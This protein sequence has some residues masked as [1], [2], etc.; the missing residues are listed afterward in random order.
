MHEGRVNGKETI[1]IGSI[2]EKLEESDMIMADTVFTIHVETKLRG[3]ELNILA[4]IS[5]REKLKSLRLQSGRVAH[6]RMHV[7]R[8]IS[9]KITNEFHT[10]NILASFNQKF[11]IC[12]MLTNLQDVLIT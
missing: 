3:M 11:L 8:V 6:T 9:Y 10:R 2:L 1:T 5:R 4:V 7:E 12:C